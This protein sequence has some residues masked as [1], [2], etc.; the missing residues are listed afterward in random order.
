MLRR[1]RSLR[2]SSVL[3]C[4]LF[5][6]P[7]SVCSLDSPCQGCWLLVALTAG[8]PERLSFKTL[9]KRR[10][11]DADLA[12]DLEAQV[13]PSPNPIAVMQI[14]GDGAAVVNVGLMETAAGTYRT[15]PASVA[16]VPGADVMRVEEL[17]ARF[18]IHAAVLHVSHF[19]NGRVDEAMAERDVARGS[20]A[21]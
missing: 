4:G 18:V 20:D 13:V 15:G 3:L 5:Y 11:A 9:Q 8:S 7:A 16:V 19:A 10:I 14:R 12:Q 6:L 2:R 17:L 21:E 1:R